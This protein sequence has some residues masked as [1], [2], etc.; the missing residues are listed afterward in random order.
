MRIGVV[1]SKEF[2]LGFR[3]AGVKLWREVSTPEEMEKAIDEIMS[4]KDIGI[5]VAEGEIAEKMRR[6]FREEIE[7]SIEPIIIL[8]GGEASIESLRER[9]R[10][11]VGVDLW[12]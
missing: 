4:E 3:L 7:E 9:I 2:T 10:V 5:L 8:V 11:S 6:E 12:K 1:G